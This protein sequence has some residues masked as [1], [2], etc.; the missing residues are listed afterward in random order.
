MNPDELRRRKDELILEDAQKA[1]INT[2]WVYQWSRVSH[3]YGDTVRQLLIIAAVF[4][5]IAAPFYTNNLA[6]ELPFIVFGVVALVSVAA[7]T[8]PLKRSA[9]SADTVVSGVGLVLFELWALQ[10]YQTDPP[11]KF[12]LREALAII[13]LAA[14]YFSTKTLRNMF[15]NQISVHDHDHDMY[16]E[17]GTLEEV[18]RRQPKWKEEAREIINEKND[19]Q[20]DDYN[21]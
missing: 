14:L 2:P 12:I 8:N 10:N 6:V 9:I 5:L 7:L 13:F 18:Q 4:M 19:R 11:F 3:Y 21:D 20:R 15:Q 16:I 1:D 17:P